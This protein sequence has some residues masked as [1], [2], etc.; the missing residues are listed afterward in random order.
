[1]DKVN[2]TVRVGASVV[3]TAEAVELLGDGGNVIFQVCDYYRGMFTIA[4][5]LAGGLVDAAR[6]VRVF[7]DDLRVVGEGF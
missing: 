1:M 5:A 6:Q 3:L 7:A 4:P 2:N